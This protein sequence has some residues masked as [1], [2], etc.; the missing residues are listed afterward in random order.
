MSVTR[1]TRIGE[2]SPPG[3]LALDFLALRFFW[4][5]YC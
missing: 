3:F 2:F 1:F 4:P 5:W